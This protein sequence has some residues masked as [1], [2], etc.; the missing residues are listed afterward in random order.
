MDIDSS[1]S[2]L[3]GGIYYTCTNLY[4]CRVIMNN[5]NVITNNSA[6]NSG[7]GV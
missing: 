5:G 2:G 7:G 6:A 4:N 1:V 3:G